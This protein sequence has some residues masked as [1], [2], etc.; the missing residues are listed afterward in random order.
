MKMK[1]MGILMTLMILM[2]TLSPLTLL[3]ASSSLLE[4]CN[5]PV[6]G[7][8]RRQEEKYESILAWLEGVWDRALTTGL[9]SWSICRVC[10]PNLIMVIIRY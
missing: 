4:P 1:I 2:L 5:L 7:R 8:A 3:T 9:S 6:S 10:Q